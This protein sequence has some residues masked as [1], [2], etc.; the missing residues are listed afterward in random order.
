[1]RGPDAV[2]TLLRRMRDAKPRQRIVGLRLGEA[3]PDAREGG[4][5]PAGE[6]VTSETG[7]SSPSRSDGQAGN[8][9]AFE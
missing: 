7:P 9:I 2:F 1:M 6:G 5:I 3:P 8:P 4:P